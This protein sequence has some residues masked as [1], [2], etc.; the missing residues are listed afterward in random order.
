M[1]YYDGKPHIFNKTI[2]PYE[3]PGGRWFVEFVFCPLLKKSSDD[4]RE[5]EKKKVDQ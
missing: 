1:A 3:D 4:P 5:R 2:K